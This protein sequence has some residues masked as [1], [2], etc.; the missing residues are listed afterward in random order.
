MK[1]KLMICWFIVMLCVFTGLNTALTDGVLFIEHPAAPERVPVPLSVKYHRVSI[2]IDNGI[3]TTSID[4]VFINNYG[5]DLEGTYLFPLP[6]EAAI[7][8]FVLYI[9][10][11]RV[12][13]EMLDRNK[14][15][16]IYEDIV[17][18]MKD[19]GLLEYIGR[20]L[21]RARVY[22]IPGHGERRIEL[23]Y[24][25][26]LGYDAGLYTYV[27]PLDTER[28][29]PEPLE[30][31][32][33]SAKVKS[34]VPIKSIYSPSHDIDIKLERSYASIGY[35]AKEVKPDKDFILYYTVSEED[36]GR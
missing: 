28:F 11:R 7:M 13:G 18:R 27:Y 17:R 25:Q 19:P 22:P 36:V 30:E 21:F 14:A 4:Q 33:I 32:T 35:E 16:K 20:N 15:R 24:S 5:M 26:T 8:D 23:V 9:D 10:G 29:S 1:R 3:A 31:V 12:S 34:P 6:E 2:E